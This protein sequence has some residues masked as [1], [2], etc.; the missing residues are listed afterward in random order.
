MQQQLRRR[1]ND[2]NRAQ[3]ELDHLQQVLDAGFELCVQLDSAAASVD[4]IGNYEAVNS[5][6]KTL[7]TMHPLITKTL[8]Q[9]VGPQSIGPALYYQYKY[10]DFLS[11]YHK[12]QRAPRLELQTLLS[13]NATWHVMASRGFFGAGNG[14]APGQRH[15][16]I[17]DLLQRIAIVACRSC[18]DDENVC[19]NNNENN[20]DNCGRDGGGNFDSGLAAIQQS[21]T[22]T[23][24]VWLSPVLAS[25]STAAAGDRGAAGPAA[26]GRLRDALLLRAGLTT[27]SLSSATSAAAD[28]HFV[29]ESVSPNNADG[30]TLQL[31]D[32]ELD[33]VL[34]SLP[35]EV[36]NKLAIDVWIVDQ[37]FDCVSAVSVSSRKYSTSTMDSQLRDN[38]H[39]QQVKRRRL[40]LLRRLCSA[41]GEEGPHSCFPSIKNALSD[42]DNSSATPAALNSTI[43]STPQR[44]LPEIHRKK[45]LKLKRKVI[46][47]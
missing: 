23:A 39:Q 40:L 4:D 42:G 47:S 7:S 1:H 17:A 8:K 26:A 22:Y 44:K 41:L 12:Y 24:D 45:R 28:T 18:G 5:L 35:I 21:M 11:N 31:L 16:E 20:S 34:D 38:V 9:F 15:R 10:L 14:V 36:V 29:D 46:N 30:S 6:F 13:A 37:C 27:H 32:A 3:V 19:G 25:T 43:I 2:E 33:S